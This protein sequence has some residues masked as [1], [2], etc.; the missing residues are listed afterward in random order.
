MKPS[1][2]DLL[3]FEPFAVG[4]PLPN[5]V[6]QLTKA[7]ARAPRSLWP[8]QLNTGTLGGRHSTPTAELSLS[9]EK[10]RRALP[11]PRSRSFVPRSLD[12]IRWQM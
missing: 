2:P 11:T 9:E 7:A 8:S 12:L 6:L 5:K 10:T 1:S 4:A 3:D